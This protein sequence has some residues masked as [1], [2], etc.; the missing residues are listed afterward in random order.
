L[1]QFHKERMLIFI[2]EIKSRS[3][4]WWGYVARMGEMLTVLSKKLKEGDH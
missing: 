3:V 2:M 1:L 4:R